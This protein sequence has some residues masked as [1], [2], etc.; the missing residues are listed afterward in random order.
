MPSVSVAVS[1]FIAVAPAV[2]AIGP[3][4]SSFA[5][6]LIFST[7]VLVLLLLPGVGSVSLPV[8]LAVFA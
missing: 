2:D 4:L 8:I 3:L 7:G 1:A 6:G 5:T